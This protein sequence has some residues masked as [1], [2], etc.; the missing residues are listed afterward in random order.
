[1]SYP[2]YIDTIHTIFIVFIHSIYRYNYHFVDM[3]E[4]LAILEIF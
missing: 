3:F 2:Q 1:M 4:F